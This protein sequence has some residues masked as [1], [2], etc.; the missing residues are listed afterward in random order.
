MH[1]FTRALET[2]RFKA[3]AG[4]PLPARFDTVYGRKFLK[5]TYGPDIITE[6]DYHNPQ[7]FIALLGNDTDGEVR[8][9]YAKLKVLA[10]NQGKA[11]RELEKENI[12]LKRQLERL[13]T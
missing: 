9:K 11:L 3:A 2:R 4:M 7:N 8:E 6:L 10:D 12:Q 13:K 5:D 1:V